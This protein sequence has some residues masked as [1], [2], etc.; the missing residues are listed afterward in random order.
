MNINIMES[1][2][3]LSWLDTNLLRVQK[4]GRYI[5]GE[6]NQIVKPWTEDRTTVA[7]AFPD[8]YDIGASN[9]GLAVLY[10]IINQRED[11]LAERVYA[12]WLDMESLMRRDR[13][14][15]YSLESKVP[16]RN[17]D[18]LGITIPY[19]TLY[20]NTLNL[21]DLAGIP[22][23]TSERDLSFPLV[24]AG[25]QSTY[26]PEP[27]SAFIDAFVIGEGEE[28]VH[29]IINVFRG[30]QLK[31][32]SRSKLL[33]SLANIWGVY[34]PSLYRAIY[35]VDGTLKSIEPTQEGVPKRV[36]KR[37]VASLPPPPEKLIVPSID[38]VHNRLSIEI[39]RGCS[40]GCRFCHAG[41]VNRPVRQRSASQILTALEKAYLAT[42]I[43]EIGLLSLSSSDHTEIYGLVESI[44]HRFADKHI[45]ISLPSLRIESFSLDLM[46]ALQGKR[47]GGFT[48]APEAAT[49]RM[50][51]IINKPIAT[52]DLLG[53]M[54][55]IF[56]RGWQTIKLYF[57]I[58]QPGETQED[59]DGIIN[60]CNQ[61]MAIG[62]KIAGRKA[63]LHVSIGTLIP[64]PHT[65]FQW[66]ATNTLDEIKEKQINLRNGLRRSSIKLMLSDPNATL[67]ES[68]LSRGD[69][70][71]S[72]VIQS[73][74]M[75]GAKFDAWQDQFNIDLWLS[76]FEI[77]EIDPAYYAHRPR[78]LEELL[79]WDHI[80]IG[81]RKS[82]LVNEF[83]N[84]L[85][86]KTR[87]DCSEQCA[88]CGI[89]TAFLELVN[90]GHTISWKCPPSK[91]GSDH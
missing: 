81:V 7:L 5:G 10:D 33:S 55:A 44:K 3:I 8:I 52:S 58:G 85:S 69:R 83:K 70:R 28:V 24:L 68:W 50:R 64:K 90:P 65:P 39:M 6:L 9:L 31:G 61:A 15:L 67:L 35:Q 27:M 51:N 71:I 36:T 60:L 23:R 79:P 77:N 25:G 88:A 47:Y 53:T 49:E 89:N 62:R 38:I 86:G 73:A 74:W 37:I 1:S 91:H 13:I 20:T 34:V 57:M 14:P 59:I 80:N 82:Y 46:D 42:G 18:I 29:D 21:L 87:R 22:L 72:D 19:E 16:V 75:N 84:S 12:P 40:R 45:N 41:M 43:E 17:F 32:S 63:N 48:L 11:S 30:W 56:N 54:T 66:A 2:R 76:A 78:P 26:N 4:P